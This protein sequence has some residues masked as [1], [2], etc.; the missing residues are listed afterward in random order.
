MLGQGSCERHSFNDRQQVHVSL[1]PASDEHPQPSPSPHPCHLTLL[2]CYR[3][4]ALMVETD[5]DF[6]VL[7]TWFLQEILLRKKRSAFS[8]IKFILV[9]SDKPTLASLSKNEH[10]IGDC[11]VF[12]GIQELKKQVSIKTTGPQVHYRPVKGMNSGL[13]P[14]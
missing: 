9:A 1:H 6:S 14:L 13:E 3:I 8:S 5:G 11:G 10:L 4:S 12:H 2:L 7:H